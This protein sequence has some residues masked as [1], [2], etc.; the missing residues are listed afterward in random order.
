M[1]N[2]LMLGHFPP[3]SG[4]LWVYVFDDGDDQ[5]PPVY[6]AKTPVPLRALAAGREIRGGEESLLLYYYYYYY[7]CEWRGI[8]QSTNKSC[9]ETTV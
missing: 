7:V 6:L 2:G 8:N 5:A 9:N 1:N 3:S 4:S